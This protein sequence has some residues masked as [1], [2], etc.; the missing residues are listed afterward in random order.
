MLP[1]FNTYLSDKYIVQS[2]NRMKK[3]S[4]ICA[5]VLAGCS[6]SSTN[7]YETT[8]QAKWKSTTIEI[9]WVAETDINSVCQNLG[10]NDSP[11]GEYNACA[12]S[13]PD[14]I[15]ICEIYAVQPTNFDDTGNL[16]VL[17]HE[18]WHCLGATH[19]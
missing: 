19:K 5:I 3:L 13:K 4:L 1:L 7:T 8:S 18:T 17:G 15:N 6:P 11:S 2:G 9:H 14:S 12:R 16:Q 10:T